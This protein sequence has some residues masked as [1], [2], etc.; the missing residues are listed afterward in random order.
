MALHDLQ[1][2]AVLYASTYEMVHGGELRAWL[3]TLAATGAEPAMDNN[4]IS[5]AATADMTSVS[6][7][8]EGSP[9]VKLHMVEDQVVVDVAPMGQLGRLVLFMSGAVDH[10][11]LPSFADR[12]ALT[13]WMQ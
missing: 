6:V 8:L 12:V 10:A 7:A 3:P 2:T 4:C 13:A 5:E 1:V 11:V 9:G